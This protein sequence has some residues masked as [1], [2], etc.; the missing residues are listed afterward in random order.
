MK[1]LV[2]DDHALI[3]QA[4]H[5]VLKKLK[6]DAE[7][8]EAATCEQAMRILAD[9]PAISLVLLDL[10]LPDRD[11]FSALAELRELYP[12]T[13]IVVLSALQDPAYVKKALDLGALGYIPKTAEPDVML[14]ALRLVV[15]G[16]IYIPAQILAHEE[17]LHGAPKQSA[18]DLPSA[19]LADIGLTDRQL[20][21]LALVMQGKSNKTICRTL[22]LAEPTV[23][24]HVTA[25]LK[26]LK[27]SNRTE[28]VITVNQLG[29]NNQVSVKH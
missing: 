20:D 5:G 12:A 4:M 3:R 21:V 8:L 13:S 9:D 11:G 27:V 15:S 29:L 23:K 18:G 26:A 6:R 17:F 24:N 7:V 22:N 25:I 2:I 19:S 28:A 16:G 14:S 1:I 10:T